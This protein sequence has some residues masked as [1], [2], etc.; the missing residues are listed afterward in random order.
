M[1]TPTCLIP[2]RRPKCAVHAGQVI[3]A[4]DG[5]LVRG[6]ASEAVKFLIIGRENTSVTVT[7][8]K[9]PGPFTSPAWS[10]FSPRHF[11]PLPP[12]CDPCF[13]TDS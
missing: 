2:C 1:L 3:V 9:V 11:V 13:H 5:V 4:V 12:H 10:I 6:M 8:R 7:V